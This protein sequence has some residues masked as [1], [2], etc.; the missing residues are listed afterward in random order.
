[1]VGEGRWWFLV[2]FGDDWWWFVVIGGWWWLVVVVRDGWWWFV[3]VC[4]G[5]WRLVAVGGGYEI[6]MMTIIARSENVARNNMQSRYIPH[7]N[8]KT[9]LSSREARILSS[10]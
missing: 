2:I 7:S 1:M 4:G 5:S 9:H 8:L 3:A 10:F 6:A